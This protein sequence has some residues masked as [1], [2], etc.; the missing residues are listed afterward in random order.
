MSKRIDI[1][2]TYKLYIGGAFPRSE[3]GRYYGLNDAKGNFIANIC[4]SSRKDF[5]NAMVSA[6]KAQ[7]G[8][9]GRSAYNRGQILYRIAEMMEGRKE[10]LISELIKEGQSSKKAVKEVETAIDRVVYFAGWSDKYQQIFGTVNPV[11]S[12][13]FNFSMPEPTGVV[14]I[15]APQSASLLGFISVVMPVIVGG[16]TVVV[17]ASHEH[18]LSTLTLTEILNTSDVPGGV[19]NVLTGFTD[20]LQSQF[21]THM[22]VNAMVYCEDDLVSL[23]KIQEDASLNVKAIVHRKIK[24]WTLEEHEN[25]Y[26]ILD[27]QE[28]KTT[29]HPVGDGMTTGGAY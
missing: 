13:H 19:I 1:Q 8:W 29:W 28:I 4:R 15:I 10:Q 22:D 6:R 5:R 14:S 2:K 25:P 3:S 26:A 20:E 12:S 21:A 9:A 17:L 24:D 23:K 27:L 16:N 7:G 11:A 18:P